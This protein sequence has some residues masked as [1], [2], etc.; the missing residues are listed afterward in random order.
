MHWQLTGSLPALIPIPCTT[1]GYG[2]ANNLAN[3]V[4]LAAIGIVTWLVTW[5]DNLVELA[6]IGIVAWLGPAL[7]HNP[8]HN[9]VFPL[10]QII[11]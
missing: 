10:E 1:L 8:T 3:L 7:I 2:T 6:A 11:S 5:L 9:F 4:E